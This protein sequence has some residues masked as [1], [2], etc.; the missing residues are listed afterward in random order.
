MRDARLYRRGRRSRRR[1][2]FECPRPIQSKPCLQ[3]EKTRCHP[4]LSSRHLEFAS[5]SA[6]TGQHRYNNQDHSM[7]TAILCGSDICGGNF[8]VWDVNIEDDYH[9]ALEESRHAERSARPPTQSNHM[10]SRLRAAFSAKAVITAAILVV[11][12]SRV[13]LSAVA[14][15]L[16]RQLAVVSP[17]YEPLRSPWGLPRFS[18]GA[19]FPARFGRDLPTSRVRLRLDRTVHRFGASSGSRFRFRAL[20]N[21]QAGD[22]DRSGNADRRG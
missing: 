18:A 9:E 21:A 19:A 16:S 13:A 3:R 11:V 22:H 7:L 14:G 12:L 20:E 5:L 2:S 10:M 8:N 17:G 6:A 15:L 4:R 1:L